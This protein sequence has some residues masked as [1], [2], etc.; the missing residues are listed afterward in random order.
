MAGCQLTGSRTEM[1]TK[2]QI[3]I[4]LHGSLSGPKLL[5]TPRN[6]KSEKKSDIF[7]FLTILGPKPALVKTGFE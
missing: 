7:L 2:N 1:K 3:E 5:N 4:F 6:R